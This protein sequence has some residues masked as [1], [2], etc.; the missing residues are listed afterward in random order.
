MTEDVRY[1][2]VGVV[3]PAYNE[4]GTVESVIRAALSVT[5]DV[6]VISDGSTDA[7]ADVARKAGA[8]VIEFPVNRGK[9]AAMQEGMDSSPCDVIVFLDG[10][11]LGLEPR[12]IRELMAPVLDGRADMAVGVFRSG[13]KA[14]DLAQRISPWLSGQRAIRREAFKDIDLR[15]ARFGAEVALTDYAR[16]R[17]ARV[18]M[19]PLYNV[20]HRM[21]EE[22][23]G[24]IPG[25]IQRARMYADVIRR[26][27]S[28]GRD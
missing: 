28:R 10:D 6:T 18:V 25:V 21:K 27:A 13:R 9:G 4:E 2:R 11:L 15:D 8:R 23:R 14:T 26:I 3:I 12:H 20:T 7:T 5:P 1:P 24:V 17:G 22:K 19:V 16:Q